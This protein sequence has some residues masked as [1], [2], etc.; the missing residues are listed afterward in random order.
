MVEYNVYIKQGQLY[1]APIRYVLMLISNNQNIKF[2]FLPQKDFADLIF[3]D[4]DQKSSV[5]IAVEF[6]HKLFISKKYDFKD[7]FQDACLI[8]DR[9]GSVDHIATVFYMINCVQ[10]YGD[11]KGSY[12]RFGRFLFEKSYQS[13]YDVIQKNLVQENIDQFCH[14]FLKNHSIK[15]FSSR[16]FVSHDIDTIYGSLFQDGYW[17]FKHKRFDV[18]LRLIFNAI[19]L[20]PDWK[21]MDMIMKINDE[22]G[23]KSTFFWLAKKGKGM[24]DI[25]NADY[26]CKTLKPL[27][28]RIEANGFFNGIHKSSSNL[29]LK[30]EIDEFPIEVNN[31]RYHFLRYKLPDLWEQIQN[32][33][34]K[35]DFSLGFAERYGFRNSYGLPFKP[36]DFKSGKPFSFIEV[37]LNLMDS[38]FS[39]YM[40]IP[41]KSTAEEIINFFEKNNSGCI[42]SLLW[43][44]TYFSNYKYRGY[45]GEYK[46]VLGYLYENKFEHITPI[47][48]V[49]EFN[50]GE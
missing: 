33:S 20:K 4:E 36:Y 49:E 35:A 1:S 41:L 37:P 16:I 12:D 28:K 38:T 7:Y 26:N 32:S 22:Y 18:M 15:Q 29:S 43:H 27:M 39:R 40:K 50:Y 6:Y 19:L 8:K 23:I 25:M 9:N 5:V 2:N 48:I 31:N 44:N 10:E 11:D 34:I 13:E 30:E 42:L 45:L 46:K 24:Y 47:E 3:D 21:N 17:A 14:K